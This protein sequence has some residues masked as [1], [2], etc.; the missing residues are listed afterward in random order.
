MACLVLDDW[1]NYLSLRVPDI[2]IN[3]EK[4]ILEKN[5]RKRDKHIRQRFSLT[6]YIMCCIYGYEVK[7]Q[8]HLWVG[9]VLHKYES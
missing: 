1:S 9:G 5:T 3:L 4:K 6:V 8:R 7:R 2:G